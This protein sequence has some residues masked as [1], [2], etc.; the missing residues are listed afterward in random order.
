MRWRLAV[1]DASSRDS[2]GTIASNGATATVAPADCSDDCNASLRPAGRVNST[3]RLRQ[4]GA[5]ID[6]IEYLSGALLEKLFGNADTQ[7][8][9]SELI[10]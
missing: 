1:C 9:S 10:G 8:I 6:R 4:S 2:S 3:R 7:K 5:A